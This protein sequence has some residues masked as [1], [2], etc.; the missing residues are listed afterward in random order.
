MG[1]I[2]GSC[3]KLILARIPCKWDGSCKIPDD[4][5][6]QI[7]TERTWTHFSSGISAAVFA[8]MYSTKI[9]QWH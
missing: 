4:A 6:T 8:S 5:V 1:N 3:Q 9:T 7:L 2:S